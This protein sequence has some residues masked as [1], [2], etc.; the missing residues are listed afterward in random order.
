MWRNGI[1]NYECDCSEFSH[2][3]HS[4]KKRRDWRSKRVAVLLVLLSSVQLELR[5]VRMV[6]GLEAVW[7]ADEELMNQSRVLSSLQ[8]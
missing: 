2:F 8:V 1:L 4:V 6:L 3:L 7:V 5:L